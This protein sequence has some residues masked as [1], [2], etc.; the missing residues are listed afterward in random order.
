MGAGEIGEVTAKILHGFG[1]EILIYDLKEDKN[2]KENY[3]VKY[4][5]I[6]DLCKKCDIITIHA[7]LTDATQHLVNKEKID[8][9]KEGVMLINT[10][11][12]AIC[13]TE[14]LIE[15]I[16]SGKIGYLGMDVYEHE[17]DIFFED[18]T[19]Q[20]IQDPM[21]LEL[22]TFNN[23]IVTSHQAFLTQEALTGSMETSLESLKAWAAGETPENELQ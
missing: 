14:D 15:G 21:M 2:L 5:S 3:G 23:V 17:Q 4:V 18:H 13:K 16:K 11:R 8:W 12:G 19:A 1:C 10:A 9:M 7:T 6:E 20:G 22:L